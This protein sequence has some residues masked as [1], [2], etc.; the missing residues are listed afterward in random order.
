MERTETKWGFWIPVK[1]DNSARYA[2]K[3]AG[4]P[5][6]LM[7]LSFIVPTLFH[8]ANTRPIVGGAYL[9]AMVFFVA[10]GLLIRKGRFGFLPVSVGLWIAVTTYAYAQSG[11]T[12]S[13]FLSIT[14]GLVAMSGLR[15]WLWLQR[16]GA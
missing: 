9:L 12:M 2:A 1:D 11:L 14:I 4:L 16:H 6:F 13:I 8:F 7:G 15:G 5:V 10:A 3:M